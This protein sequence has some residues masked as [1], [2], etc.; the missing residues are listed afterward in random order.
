MGVNE[1]KQE[2]GKLEC[3]IEN[4]QQ[5]LNRLR[6]RITDEVKPFVKPLLKENVEKEVRSNSEHTKGLGREKLS[7]MK[8]ELMALVDSS[9]SLVEKVLTNNDFWMHVNYDID[10]ERYMYGISREE[11]KGK[12]QKGIKIILGE[13]GKL[14]IDYGYIKAGTMYQ[15]DNTHRS[16][17]LV[18]SGQKKSDLL[19]KE[20]FSTP[21]SLK[22]LMEEYAKG[23]GALHELCEK[24]SD[25]KKEL[26]EQE[27]A[28]LWDEV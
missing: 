20:Y 6:Q 3:S 23:L 16:F 11:V 9:D 28:D 19:Y 2:I 12:I 13:A 24:V 18:D 4:K 15:W 10:D 27:A 5:D 8:Q 7:A 17:N 14:L 1:I 22:L 26:S 25:L 21:N